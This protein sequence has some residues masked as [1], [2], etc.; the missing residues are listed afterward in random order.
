MT[1]QSQILAN[2]RNAQKS[3]GPKTAVGKATA[4]QNATRHGLFARKD[5]VFSEDQAQFDAL[6]DEILGELAPEGVMETILAE[7]IVSLTWRL[8]RAQQMQDEVI[9][10][11]MRLEIESSNPWLSKALMAG[12]G[13]SVKRGAKK[14]KRCYDDLALGL[15]GKWDFEGD[16]VLERLSM[17]ERRFEASL[18]R[19]MNEFKKL[20]HGRKRE[21]AGTVER[22]GRDALATARETQGQDALATGCAKR[23]Q[24]AEGQQELSGFEKREYELLLGA[25]PTPNEANDPYWKP[26]DRGRG[27][28][29]RP[30]RDVRVCRY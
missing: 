11:K 19:T 5:V 12:T 16:K 6:R 20:K 21:R 27:T 9:D 28:E 24:C 25:P 4:A 15:I 14:P 3:T 22:Q 2:R 7:R 29:L 23:S 10:V 18:F 1:T 26:E 17:Y 13:L 8:K 30:R